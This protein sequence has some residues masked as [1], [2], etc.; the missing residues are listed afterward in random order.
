MGESQANGRI[1]ELGKTIREYVKVYK[2]K[3]EY[4]VKETLKSEDPIMQWLLRWAA[5]V[6]SRYKV[7][8]DGKTPYESLKGRKCSMM[9][10]PFGEHVWYKQLKEKDCRAGHRMESDW[11]KGVW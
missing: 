7:G 6:G 5:M 11:M 2:D 3:I 1:E 8:S 4:E 10:V 9:A